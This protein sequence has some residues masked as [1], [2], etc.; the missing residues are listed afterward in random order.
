MSE[1]GEIIEGKRVSERERERERV[2]G[3]VERRKRNEE[4]RKRERGAKAMGSVSFSWRVG[5]RSSPGRCSS[6]FMKRKQRRDN[7]LTFPR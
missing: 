7:Y 1:E 4:E 2:R 3:V 6:R 5:R